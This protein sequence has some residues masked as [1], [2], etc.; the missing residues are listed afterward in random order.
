MLLFLIPAAF[1]CDWL[2]YDDYADGS[3]D[4]R[5]YGGTFVSGGWRPDGG[6]IVYD[7]PDVV[8]GNITM[9]LSNVDEAG[10]SQTDLLELFSGDDGSFSDSRR[11]NFL[12]VKFAG[13]IYDGYDGRVK[14]QAGPEWYGDIEVGAWTAE[15]NWVAEN[16]YDFSIS[17]GGTTASMDIASTLSSSIDYSHYGE[18]S[19]RTLR[20]PN[21]T[22]YARDTLMDDIIIAGVSLCGT[23]GTTMIEPDADTDVDA[24]TDADTDTDT[25]TDTDSDADAD[26]DADA[27]SDADTGTPGEDG[28]D[29]LT[30]PTVMS[31]DVEPRDVT[32]GQDWHVEWTVGGMADKVEFCLAGYSGME[33]CVPMDLARASRDVTT[34]D[35]AAGQYAGTVRV[36]GPGGEGMSG[37]LFLTV[38]APPPAAACHAVPGALSWA[39]GAAAAGLVARRRARTG[40]T[41]ANSAS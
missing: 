19:F 30:A 3:S 32:Q 34:T 21:D 5:T 39:L 29:T 35:I 11:D 7:L 27:D 26:A 1:T 41:F 18:L 37:T 33:H 31:F 40:G 10:V 12:Q 17:W 20:I 6:T 23:P 16:A 9:R 22:T 28:G 15:Y 24:D 8:A 14:L 13:D 38:E 2:I 25:D 36:S 4:G